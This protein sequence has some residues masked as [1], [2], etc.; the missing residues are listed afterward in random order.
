MISCQARLGTGLCARLLALFTL[1]CPS[2]VEPD[3]GEHK[4]PAALSPTPD[5]RF[6]AVSCPRVCPRVR[7]AAQAI[8]ILLGAGKAMAA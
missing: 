4:A 1:L 2:I 7:E 6:L 8:V 3:L 5:Q